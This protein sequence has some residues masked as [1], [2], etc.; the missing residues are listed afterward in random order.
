MYCVVNCLHCVSFSTKQQVSIFNNEAK[1]D[2]PKKDNDEPECDV[3]KEFI[4]KYNQSLEDNIKLKEEVFQLQKENVDLKDMI[5]YRDQ[6]DAH[7]P[8]EPSTPGTMSL[9]DELRIETNLETEEITYRLPI[10]SS[11]PIDLLPNNDFGRELQMVVVKSQQQQV[12]RLEDKV[13]SYQKNTETN[14]EA[15]QFSNKLPISSSSPIDDAPP[16]DGDLVRELKGEVEKSQE[17]IKRLEDE[18][19]HYQKNIETIK[20]KEKQMINDLAKCEN[21]PKKDKGSWFDEIGSFW[22]ISRKKRVY[23]VF[24]ICFA[25]VWKGFASFSPVATLQAKVLPYYTVQ[26]ITADIFNQFCLITLL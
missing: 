11:S 7:S 3:L 5:S 9:A 16:N 22:F 15:E 12:K 13:T 10:S 14:F 1:V 2:T 20:E 24:L 23:F 18:V 26:E 25:L 17:Q 4:A 8:I 6:M 19:T 21:V